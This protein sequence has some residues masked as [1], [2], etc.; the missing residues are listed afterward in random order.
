MHALA[1]PVP[2]P[3]K[4]LHLN[5]ASSCGKRTLAGAL[6]ASLVQ[7]FWHVSIDHFLAAGMLPRQRIDRGEFPWRGLRPSFFEGCQR[8]LPALAQAGN[9]LIVEHIVET[10]VWLQRL[11]QLLAL[12]DV[13]HVGLHRALPELERHERERADRRRRR[14]PC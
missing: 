1:E 7:P 12:F 11:V 3:G 10:K 2:M 8:C 13:F 5:G 4:I 9:N 6:Q 14:G